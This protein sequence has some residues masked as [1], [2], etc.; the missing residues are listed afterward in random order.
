[1][2]GGQAQTK[3]SS[4]ERFQAEDSKTVIVDS[5]LLLELQGNLPTNPAAEDQVLDAI[6]VRS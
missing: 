3:P 2:V 4:V 1:M 6:E 5:P